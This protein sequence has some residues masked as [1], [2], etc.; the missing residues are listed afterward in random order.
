MRFIGN[1]S[2]LLSNIEAVINENCNGDEN[3]FCDIFSGTSS[4]ARYFKNRYKV[5]SNDMLYFSYILQKATIENNKIPNF[6]KLKSEGIIDV[7]EYLETFEVNNKN[8]FIAD[9]YAPNENCDRMYLTAENARRIDFIR[10]KIE[11]WKDKK[12]IKAQEYNYL[13][14]CLIEGVPYVSNITGTYGA[15]LKEWDKRAYKDFEMIRLNVTDNGVQ[16]ECYNEDANELIKNISGD[17]LYID[18]PYNSR[19]YLPNYHLLETIAKYDNP[20]I[21]GKTGVREYSEEKSE[22]CVKTQ[23][24]KQ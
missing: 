3:V 13:L 17:I 21:N 19:Q 23:V 24:A 14:A 12:L 6:L 22:Y 1:K 18:P 5:I 8:S 11:E 9:N 7:F 2:N 10:N 20:I 15:Y 4:V 16:N